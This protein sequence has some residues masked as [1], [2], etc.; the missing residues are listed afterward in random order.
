LIVFLFSPNATRRFAIRRRVRHDCRGRPLHI[1]ED[2][3]AFELHGVGAQILCRRRTQRLAGANVELTLMQRA[4]DPA[5]L[6]ET[7]AQQ[8][9]RMGTNSGRGKDLVR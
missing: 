8:S 5:V 6:D 3:I 4:L 2:V 7:L 9:E 1:D